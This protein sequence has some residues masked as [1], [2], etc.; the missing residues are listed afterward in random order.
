MNA[1]PPEP[2]RGDEALALGALAAGI[3]LVAGYP[4]SPATGIFEALV[5]LS[6][7]GPLTLEWA[8]NE[9]VAME[10]AIGASLAGRRALVVVKGV[11]L[12]IALDPLATMSYSG[13]HTGLV[14]AVGDDPAG[15][16]S[17]NEQD[18]RWLAR[19]AEVP[20]VEATETATAAAL[21]AQAFAW[22]EGLYTP[23]ILR[24]TRGLAQERAALREPPWQ[25][26]PPVGR[27]IR[28]EDRWTVYPRVVVRRHHSLHR[29][30][31]SFQQ[32]LASSPYDVLCGEGDLGILAGGHTFSKVLSLGQDLAGLS[33]LGL[34]SA[35]PLPEKRLATW[36]RGLRRLLVLEEGGPFVEEQVRA[37]AQRHGLPLEIWGRANRALP[38]EGEL[39]PKEIASAI[40]ALTGK[41][42]FVPVNTFPDVAMP[43]TSLC[44]D[45]P[46]R[47]TFD[48][49]RATMDRLGGRERYLIVG[50]TSCMVR[51]IQTGLFD[52]K[53]SLGSALG[54][55]LGL[56][57]HEK[58]H[59][60][61]ALLG[62]S[63]FFHS[64]VNALSTLVQRQVPLTVIL[65]DNDATAQTGGQP[66]P[67]TPY[68]VHRTPRPRVEIERVIAAYGLE[69]EILSPQQ[70]VALQAAFESALADD[71]PRVLIVREPCPRYRSKEEP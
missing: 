15:W 50:E 45:C 9:K 13:C 46:Y 48:A 43:A 18:S 44:E 33:L 57:L 66:H 47:P 58:R 35:W 3:G 17:Q 19:L 60:V 22:S 37:M 67:G 29:R 41:A 65:L 62:D 5:R 69:A 31:R 55:A 40:E 34:A 70:P 53:Y 10:M 39:G 2:V 51:A 27:F 59:R 71:R 7:P 36:M 52:V 16:S 24:L 14:I 21:M 8:A 61:I 4:G 68:D 49:L 56:A 11:G 28:K 30:L 6:A 54:I 26:P 32:A 20:I 42:P 12:N 1:T 64:E 63:C 38:E 23:I 25:L